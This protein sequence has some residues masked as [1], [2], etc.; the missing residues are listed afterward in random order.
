[1]TGLY[2]CNNNAAKFHVTSSDL[3]SNSAWGV[4]IDSLLENVSIREVA[5]DTNGMS[6]VNV[7][8]LAEA[9]KSSSS[10]SSVCI[11]TRLVR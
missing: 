2:W 9:V 4:I 3:R 1:M 6:I 7:E 11:E 5:F 8:H 10:I